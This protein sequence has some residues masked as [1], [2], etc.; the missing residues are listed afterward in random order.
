MSQNVASTSGA[1]T[2]VGSG[3][4]ADTIIGSGNISGL[5]GNDS[6]LGSAELDALFGNDGNDSLLGDAGNDCI[7]GGKDND[8]TVG[9]AGADLEFG[10]AGDDTMFGN[11]DNDT[12]YGG[13]VADDS[14][15]DGNVLVG[16]FGNDIVFGTAGKETLLG[17]EDNDLVNAGGG[18]DTV[19]GGK[20]NDSVNGDAGDDLLFGNEGSNAIHGG[21]GIDHASWAGTATGVYDAVLGAVIV[22]HGSGAD[23]VYNDVEQLVWDGVEHSFASFIPAAAT[24]NFSNEAFF[25]TA[26]PAEHVGSN[27]NLQYGDGSTPPNGFNGIRITTND[28]LVFNGEDPV[29]FWTQRYRTVA[30]PIVPISSSFD[31]TTLELVY[32]VA[33]GTQST[34]NGSINN[35]VT[36]AATNDDPGFGNAM[37]AELLNSGAVIERFY[38]SN[39]GAG[40]TLVRLHATSE[41]SNPFSDSGVVWRLDDNSLGPQDD[42]GDTDTTINSFNR[43]FGV[44]TAASLTPGAEFDDYFRITMPGVGL[45]AEIHM[46]THLV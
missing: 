25:Y 41:P 2:L 16:G 22:T 39:P 34:A 11:Q 1:D 13:L 6:I 46:E 19:F 17:N 15:T 7:D 26:L 20:G 32:E 35:N 24:P 40:E 9:N 4:G 44:V 37:L 31:G 29:L 8:A 12:L 30:E 38:D 45:I 14:E 5:E 33:A 43:L 42:G 10:A 18:T 21:S 23:T 3:N 27:G 28:A 36:R